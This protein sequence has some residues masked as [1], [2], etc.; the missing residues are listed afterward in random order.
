MNGYG[1]IWEI[2]PKIYLQKSMSMNMLMLAF[3]S[4]LITGDMPIWAGGGWGNPSIF[5]IINGSGDPECDAPTAAA[6]WFA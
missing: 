4:H 1:N 2:F 3:V 6:I 5:G